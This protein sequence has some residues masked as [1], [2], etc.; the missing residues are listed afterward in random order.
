MMNAEE[1][2]KHQEKMGGFKDKDSCMAYMG[3][4]HK[5]MEARAK[6]KGQKMPRTAATV[7]TT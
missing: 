3:E 1:R 5:S 4:H 6:Q 2:K 7:A